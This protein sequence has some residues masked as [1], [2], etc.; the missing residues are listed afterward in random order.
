MICADLVLWDKEPED[1]ST[2]GTIGQMGCIMYLCTLG[3][4]KMLGG[5]VCL[6]WMHSAGVVSPYEP[7][8]N[9]V[10]VYC[11]MSGGYTCK[12]RIPSSRTLYF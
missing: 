3:W 8:R 6:G 7:I 5:T 1:G 2:G 4:V 12:S 11:V 10:L 9:I